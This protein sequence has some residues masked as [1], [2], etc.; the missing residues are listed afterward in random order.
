MISSEKNMPGSSRTIGASRN[1]LRA[2]AIMLCAAFLIMLFWRGLFDPSEGRYAEA[3][4]EMVE[5]GQWLTMRLFGYYYYEKPPLAYW[6]VVPALALFG[7]HDWAARVPLL[8]NA[9]LLAALCF[10]LVRKHWNGRNMILP[11]IVSASSV[12]MLAGLCILLTDPFLTLWFGVTCVLLFLG[13]ERDASHRRRA[14]FLVLAALAAFLGFLTK[15][16][17]AVVLPGAILFV[18]LLWERRLSSLLTPGLVPA[19][20]IFLG[21]LAPALWFLEQHNPGFFYHFIYEEHIAR[22]TGTREM[23]LH[24]EPPYFYLLITPVLLLPWSFFLVR[25][26]RAMFRSGALSIRACNGFQQENDTLTRFLVVWTL[27]V[28]GF[29][30]I[31][32]G[33]MMSYILPALPPLAL[34]LGR[35]GIA[36]PMDGSQRDARF[37]RFGVGGVVFTAATVVLA[38][39]ISYSRVLSEDIIDQIRGV[40]IVALL[41]MAATCVLVFRKRAFQSAEALILISST[42][43]LA[44]A[45]VLS[46]LAGKNFNAQ[47]PKNS[48][49]IYKQFASIL[50]P[51]DRV[52]MLWDYRPSL[53]FYI[54]RPVVLFQEI[55]ELA[56]GMRIEPDR[57]DRYLDTIEELV[58]FVDSAPGRVFAIVEPKFVE[59]RFLPMNVR[60]VRLAIEGN[61]DTVFFQLLP[62]QP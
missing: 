5:S 17:V 44:I 48:A 23:Q 14:M 50:E 58:A 38:W 49:I 59:D 52:V 33:K 41:P 32:T 10:L 27:V 18:W 9:I 42:I 36:E 43:L 12:G 35:W 39:L 13:F 19:A 47:V 25:A 31:S 28:I 26:V 60:H 1:F 3:P 16:A 34:L 29:F 40:S 61:R 53:P 45:I 57:K 4:R 56:Y 15:G 2:A 6:T 62:R 55:N 22:F 20:I 30:S 7:I 51:D 8:I 37:W 11:M 21:L 54:Q 46:P 24:P